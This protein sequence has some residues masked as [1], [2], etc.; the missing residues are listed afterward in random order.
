MTEFKVGDIVDYGAAKG[1]TVAEVYTYSE[2]VWLRCNRPDGSI[3]HLAAPA[4]YF[5]RGREP[6][7][8]ILNNTFNNV[9][10]GEDVM[11][12]VEMDEFQRDQAR[13]IRA[14]FADTYDQVC[15]AVHPS[16][17]RSLALTKLEEACMWAIKAIVPRQGE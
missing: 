3:A 10:I 16:P 14:N 7:A 5:V 13:V 4:M 9:V 1:L 2:V 12:N 17:E 15:M 11:G 8:G 6:G